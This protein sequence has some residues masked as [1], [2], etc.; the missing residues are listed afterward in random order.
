MFEKYAKLGMNGKKVNSPEDQA[1]ITSK[2]SIE[3]V[4]C[5]AEK[6]GFDAEQKKLQTIEV[7]EFRYHYRVVGK[8][9]RLSIHR[10]DNDNTVA[11]VV[12]GNCNE[13]HIKN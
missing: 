13:G 8:K 7:G 11:Y 5:L 2:T 9:P 3:D 4:K 12:G 6:L 10:V 1:E